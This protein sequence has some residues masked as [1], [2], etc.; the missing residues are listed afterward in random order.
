MSK[1]SIKAQRIVS[2]REIIQMNNFTIMTDVNTDVL[3]AYAAAEGIVILPQYYHFDDGIV[4]GDEI[5]LTQ[6][7]FYERLAKG[8]KSL[9]M[10]CNPAR[11]QELFEKELKKGNDIL[12]I[13]FSSCLSGSY[14]TAVTVA[15]ELMEQYTDRKIYVIDSLNASAGAGMMVYMARDLQKEGIGAQ[16]IAQRIEAA[17]NRFNAVFVVDDLQYLVRGGRLSTFSGAVGTILDIKPILHINEGRIEA[18]RKSRTRKKALTDLLETVKALKPDEKYIA[19]V[20][21]KDENAAREYVERIRKETGMDIKH[22][23]PINPTIGAHTGPNA[24]GIGFLSK[25]E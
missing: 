24:L 22:I 9:S 19:V 4:Y 1:V 7:E 8:E 25:E 16:E 14:S 21:T 12:C 17:K 5:T 18:F 13:M 10:G 23:I 11:V 3:P 2:K 15:N 20:Y 6:E